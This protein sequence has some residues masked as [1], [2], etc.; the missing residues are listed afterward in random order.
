WTL[1]RGRSASTRGLPTVRSRYS[2]WS[3]SGEGHTWQGW[4]GWTGV[5][6][7]RVETEPD[8]LLITLPVERY[9]YRWP[10]I[11]DELGSRTARAEGA[12]LIGAVLA[13][14]QGG[15]ARESG[16]P[17]PPRCV[18]IPALAEHD[19]GADGTGPSANDIGGP[20]RRRVHWIRGRVEKV[21]KCFDEVLVK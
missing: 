19:G 6:I 10:A 3:G 17:D 11:A 20:V 15:Q 16:E 14:V 5:C 2:S 18:G 13:L 4:A 12:I 21:E 8:P 1:P 9:R 7:P